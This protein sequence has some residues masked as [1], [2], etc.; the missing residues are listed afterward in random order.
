[1]SRSFLPLALITLGV[2]FLLS[3]F[4]PERGRGGLILLGIGAAFV[5]GRLTT[6][7]YGYA[8]P[9][10]MLIAIG[11]YVGLQDVQALQF[12][13]GPGLFFVLLGLGFVLVYV[14][15][16]QPTAV[17]P[18]FPAAI[19]IGLGLIV[20]GVTSLAPLAAFGWIISYW[21][22][23]LVLLGLWLLFRDQLPGPVRRPVATVGG[24]ALLA[25]GILAAAASVA[26]GGTLARSGFAPSFRQSDIHSEQFERSKRHPLWRWAEYSRS[27]H[28]S[29]RHWRR[30][31]SGPTGSEWSWREPGRVTIYP[32]LAIR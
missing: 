29:L 28:T 30:A 9:A 1:L 19:L 8:V 7:R 31:A 15:G 26:A 2:V 22:A 11:A 14:I 3:N 18:L 27:R 5:L 13:H 12:T 21:P 32:T 6:G 23:V 20:L 17:W 4:I 10:G 16:S 24:L 25:Y